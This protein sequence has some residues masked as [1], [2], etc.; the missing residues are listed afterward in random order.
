MRVTPLVMP[1]SKRP[2]R[3]HWGMVLPTRQSGRRCGSTKRFR[4]GLTTRGTPRAR[5]TAARSAHSGAHPA[6]LLVDA[7]ALSWADLELSEFARAFGVSDATV[8]HYLD[9]F[10]AT[11]VVRQLAPWHE[12]ISKRQVKSPKVY[13]E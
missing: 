12:N 3:R 7:G 5:S 2:V 9:L 11:F 8:R 1:L 6:R 13:V 4:A 10:S